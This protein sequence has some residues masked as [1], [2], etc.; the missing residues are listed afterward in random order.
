MQLASS[1]NVVPPSIKDAAVKVNALTIYCGLITRAANIDTEAVTTS[2]GVK[3][4]ATESHVE[5]LQ[6]CAKIDFGRKTCSHPA[7]KESCLQSA[8]QISIMER[9]EMIDL[10]DDLKGGSFYDDDHNDD[11]RLS[12]IKEVSRGKIS[13][14]TVMENSP[15]ASQSR[16]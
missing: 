14:A 1:K 4:N 3:K 5:F 12:L 16:H 11:L 10:L 9:E 13:F 2:A 8:V 7:L 6:R 15:L